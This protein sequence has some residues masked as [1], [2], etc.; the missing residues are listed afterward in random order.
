[1]IEL[2][3][4]QLTF[5]FPHVHPDARLVI[6]FQRTL[7]IPHG[8]GDMPQLPSLGRYP[9][10]SVADYSHRVPTHWSSHG[11]AMLP[12]YQSEAMWLSFRPAYS[13]AHE[14]FYPFAVK[15]GVGGRDAVGGQRW[16]D[17]IHQWPQD[18][19]VIAHQS[20]LGGY[21]TGNDGIRQFVA[22]PLG[23]GYLPDDSPNSPH[24]FGRLQLVVYP[25][26]AQAFQSR[27]PSDAWQRRLA[28][29]PLPS[30]TQQCAGGLPAPGPDALER[31]SIEEGLF[32][33]TDWDV[34]SSGSYSLH[35]ANSL[36]WCAITGGPPPM[37]PPR[38]DGNSKLGTYTDQDI[39]LLWADT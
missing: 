13:V 15:I 7:R 23:F 27:Y 2:S 33:L 22:M 14:A 34:Q 29:M 9:L 20:W 5:S 38:P 12:M 35:L 17:G 4:D 36:H 30:P 11:G 31:Q 6:E 8:G 10:Y 37:T 39:D 26:G 19:L 25:M 16:S 24:R 1:M 21:Q 32:P 3:H 28:S 18:F